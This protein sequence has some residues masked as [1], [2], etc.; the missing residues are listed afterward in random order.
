MKKRLL[1]VI[2]ILFFALLCSAQNQI[3]DFNIKQAESIGIPI[4]HVE[5]T[6]AGY[7][8]LIYRRDLIKYFRAEYK[9]PEFIRTGAAE[10]DIANFNINLKLWYQQYPQFVD[11]LDLRNYE[12]M[13]KYDASC[14]DSPPEYTKGCS[15]AEENAYRK[16]FNN[17]MAHHPDVPKIMGDDKAAIEKH[18]RELAEF[19]NRF[20]KK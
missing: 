8:D 6:D 3:S 9:M 18:E 10:K 5:T 17:W 2:A 14:Y 20:Y 7:D 4:K 11:V 1:L 13:R 12:Q 15:E 16:R 19:Y